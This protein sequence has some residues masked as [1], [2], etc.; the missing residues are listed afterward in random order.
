MFDKIKGETVRFRGFLVSAIPDGIFN[1]NQ[2][3]R[4][5][6]KTSISIANLFKIRVLENGANRTIFMKFSCKEI[7]GFLFNSVNIS[8]PYSI[9]HKTMQIILLVFNFDGVME[10]S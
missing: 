9:H 6:Q 2:F 5:D 7:P 8:N 4:S 1:F 10:E 3:G